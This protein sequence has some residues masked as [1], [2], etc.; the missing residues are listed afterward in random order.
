MIVSIIRAP[1]FI[2]SIHKNGWHKSND[3]IQQNAGRNHLRLLFFDIISV[4]LLSPVYL[5]LY[6]FVIINFLNFHNHNSFFIQITN[7]IPNCI[8]IV[9]RIEQENNNEDSDASQKKSNQLFATHFNMWEESKKVIMETGENINTIIVLVTVYKTSELYHQVSATGWRDA[10]NESDRKPATVI[11]RVIAKD[12]VTLLWLLPVFITIRRIS[13][14]LPLINKWD[15][16]ALSNEGMNA[17][18]EAPELF[19]VC[20]C[21][22]TIIRAGELHKSVVR[23]GW[24]DTI[25]NKIA[26]TLLSHVI[27]DI[28]TFVM[29]LIAVLTVHRVPEIIKI[30]K[31][32]VPVHSHPD[33]LKSR[34]ER[35][36]RAFTVLFTAVLSGVL[37]VGRFQ[38]MTYVILLPV[39]FIPRCYILV[40]NGKSIHRSLLQL[41]LKSVK[42]LPE[43]LFAV[44]ICVTIWRINP[45]QHSIRSFGWHDSQHYYAR[46]VARTQFVYLML[47]LISL[48]LL[49]PVV[50]SFY[51]LPTCYQ[52]IKLS[53]EERITL[54]GPKPFSLNLHK[55]LWYQCWLV[56]SEMPNWCCGAVVLAAGYRFEEVQGKF[57][58]ANNFINNKKQIDHIEQVAS[59][60]L[61]QILNMITDVPYFI[62]TLF[63]SASWRT[64]SKAVTLMMINF[65]V[66]L[67]TLNPFLINSSV[68]WTITCLEIVSIVF[69]CDT[70]F[71]VKIPA[72][73]SVVAA[74]YIGWTFR[75]VETTCYSS[76]VIPV[77]LLLKINIVISTLLGIQLLFWSF[78]NKE[79]FLRSTAAV[80]IVSWSCYL[81][82]FLTDVPI[83]EVLPIMVSLTVALNSLNSISGGAVYSREIMLTSLKK[84]ILDICAMGGTLVLLLTV[85]RLRETI[86]KVTQRKSNEK[87]EQ[88]TDF[89]DVILTE[90]SKVFTD[91]CRMAIKVT[92]WRDTCHKDEDIEKRRVVKWFIEV[93]AALF[94]L[95]PMTVL[96]FSSMWRLSS[97][98]KKLSQ[99]II[100][101]SDELFV[102]LCTTAPFV[103]PQLW[104][105]VIVISMLL[106][107][108]IRTRCVVIAVVETLL[109]IITTPLYLVLHLTWRRPKE[110][111]YSDTLFSTYNIIIDMFHILLVVCSLWRIPVVWREVF[112]EI[113]TKDITTDDDK[114]KVE[115]DCLRRAAVRSEF[116]NTLSDVVSL[117][118]LIISL[119]I[120]WNT[121]SVVGEVVASLL[122]LTKHCRGSTGESSAVKQSPAAS[123]VDT[124]IVLP[125][126]TFKDG[127]LC[128]IRLLVNCD[129]DMSLEGIQYLNISIVGHSF[130]TTLTTEY[131]S[132]IS[133][134]KNTLF[135][136]KVTEQQTNLFKKTSNKSFYIDIGSGA[137]G[138]QGVSQKKV[139]EVLSNM[140]SSQWKP[141]LVRISTPEG[142]VLCEPIFVLADLVPSEKN[143]T[144]KVKKISSAFESLS[145]EEQ[146]G[147]DECLLHAA[148]QRHL[149]TTIPSFPF[150]C[151][152]LL[153]IIPAPWLVLRIGRLLFTPLSDQKGVAKRISQIKRYCFK[154]VVDHIG[155][156]AILLISITLWRLPTLI[157]RIR[158]DR[159][160]W[161]K[162]IGEQLIEWLVDVFQIF[163]MI[164]ILGTVVEFPTFVLR[165]FKFLKYG[166][167]KGKVQVRTNIHEYKNHRANLNRTEG[168]DSDEGFFLPNDVLNE[169]FDFL[170]PKALGSCLRVN[171][172]WGEVASLDDRWQ[173]HFEND[174]KPEKPGRRNRKD[175]RGISDAINRT[176]EY[177]PSNTFKSFIQSYKS[178][179]AME[180]TRTN[181]GLLPPQHETDW[182]QGVRYVI[183]MEFQ[184]SLS[185]FHHF[186][187]LP[188]K[189]MGLAQVPVLY[190][191]RFI[192]CKIAPFGGSGINVGDSIT[193]HINFYE[194]HILFG[195]GPMFLMYY[196]GIIISTLLA[197]S[198]Q[199]IYKV[200][201]LGTPIWYKHF[202]ILRPV[203]DI[204]LGVGM[205]CMFVLQYVLAFQIPFAFFGINI[206]DYMLPIINN[207]FTL[208]MYELMIYGISAIGLL[209][210]YG[211]YFLIHHAA[212]FIPGSG[213]IVD[214]CGQLLSETLTSEVREQIV[215][216][217]VREVVSSYIV[218]LM[219]ISS[220]V[221]KIV[222]YHVEYLKTVFVLLIQCEETLLSYL[223]LIVFGGTEY[224][225][226]AI[227]F[228]IP[229]WVKILFMKLFWMVT[230]FFSWVLIYEDQAT[231]APPGSSPSRLYLLPYVL[232]KFVCKNVILNAFRCVRF[233]V[234]G[235]VAAYCAVLAKITLICSA[236][237]LLGD[238]LLTA[239]TVV[240]VGWP[241]TVPSKQGDSSLY[242]TST[243]MSLYLIIKARRVVAKNW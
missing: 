5:T 187:L 63:V 115:V 208:W 185:Q 66:L 12:F 172:Q 193:S 137:G 114:Q 81:V 6:R 7:R 204:L 54:R 183:S 20:C 231:Y 219:S 211:S 226:S 27:L 61:H 82:T 240:W 181:K 70:S 220:D 14:C 40:A 31:N 94:Q 129:R 85:Y 144:E 221:A 118:I 149:F 189:L 175:A 35:Y 235:V 236:L 116:L 74:A 234:R 52:I 96:M 125:S 132:I 18:G 218:P 25:D 215:N 184:K 227:L 160:R 120:P 135:P 150:E 216:L 75:T 69:A 71:F 188:F 203:G 64:P 29:L 217:T 232:L 242:I 140:K 58:V 110:F 19:C 243:A 207:S 10:P 78:L 92:M 200:V 196:S 51:R 194:I 214:Y 45:L 195:L 48:I 72:A 131:G 222:P 99:I 229:V 89:H 84:L 180:A 199:L 87:G 76:R 117:L 100:Q 210:E 38:L 17:L 170:P 21:G 36:L 191:F 142:R 41:S 34:N 197:R 88:I 11:C 103:T 173:R 44:V 102:A 182:K 97:L 127:N 241:M 111:C 86:K 209:F 156:I 24:Q 167:R 202:P 230:V 62:P 143:H 138:T 55:Q 223:W 26:R 112:S 79:L 147:P 13:R 50:L 68:L 153:L 2:F 73:G 159:I 233:V 39:V 190:C 98:K 201:T 108:K 33:T 177:A 148:A 141:F 136:L 59:E 101:P 46:H 83:Y 47:D 16:Q 122:Q 238:L 113:S 205:F 152:L 23:I 124:N 109:D 67:V 171:E 130:W 107:I 145:P 155:I 239:I 178:L 9:R 133:I 56:I 28:I 168:D 22:I 179:Y 4:I 119:L 169:V 3:S 224:V 30:F 1:S 154:V 8:Q 42:E 198:N 32:F 206:I 128:G 176:P 213:L 65:V 15:R 80:F 225:I 95:F 151:V 57:T 139:S 90:V 93:L 77:E 37:I 192:A 212:P 161:K 121:I 60:C 174:F 91:V 165:M 164:Y 158:E 228:A 105:S 186:L 157:K 106:L 43:V 166:F 134:A 53:I 49:I 163:Q 146:Q 237:G 162:I 123:V 126:D 104:H